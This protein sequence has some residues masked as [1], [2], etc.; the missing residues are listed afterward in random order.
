LAR[1]QVSLLPARLEDYIVADAEVRVIDAFADGLD[2]AVLG[3]GRAVPA[4][5]GR[6]DYDPRDL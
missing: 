5:M 3:F 1:A 2:L 4:A 6:P